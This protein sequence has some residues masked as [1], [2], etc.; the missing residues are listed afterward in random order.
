MWRRRPLLKICKTKWKVM[1]RS[2]RKYSIHSKI[3][4]ILVLMIQ[5]PVNLVKETVSLLFLQWIQIVFLQNSWVLTNALSCSSSSPWRS[6]KAIKFRGDLQNPSRPKR[7]YGK[8]WSNNEISSDILFFS[9]FDISV[10]INSALSL[11]EVFARTNVWSNHWGIESRLFLSN[12][13]VLIS[14]ETIFYNW[15]GSCLVCTRS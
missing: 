3:A 10:H 14:I 15:K 12:I 2:I 4:G 13:L 5:S 6:K 7:S 1:N 9:I 11:L 8:F